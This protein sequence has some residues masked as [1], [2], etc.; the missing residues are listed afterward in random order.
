[1]G[2]LEARTA[3]EDAP[4]KSLEIQRGDLNKFGFTR[5]CRKCDELCR[6]DFSRPNL[7]HASG[8]R[9][10]VYAGMQKDPV[11]CRCFAGHW[12]L[13][14]LILAGFCIRGRRILHRQAPG[15]AK[16]TGW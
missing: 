16:A 2:N 12:N 9:R 1:M 7:G 5:G 10:R 6:G 8:C 14:I 15:S 4:P 3:F 13:S 11:L